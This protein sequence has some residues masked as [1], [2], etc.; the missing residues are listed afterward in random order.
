MKMLPRHNA[1]FEKSTNDNGFTWWNVF[2]CVE[3]QEGR[4]VLIGRIDIN[5][6]G[7]D[8][9]LLFVGA[10]GDNELE[11]EA[12]EFFSGHIESRFIYQLADF[13]RETESR[14]TETSVGHELV[15]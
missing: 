10:F 9:P 14:M 13:M 6:Y 12:A 5:S 7:Y 8:S 4:K 1:V 2:E 3:G 15:E 11:P